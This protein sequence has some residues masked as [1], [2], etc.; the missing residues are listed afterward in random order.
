MLTGATP[1]PSA[2]HPGGCFT[3]RYFGHHIGGD[4]VQCAKPRHEHVRSQAHNGC[5]FWQ[6]EPGADFEEETNVCIDSQRNGSNSV[7]GG[8]C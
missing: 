2:D 7:S 8:A 4:T 5:A 1:S 6:R 3:C